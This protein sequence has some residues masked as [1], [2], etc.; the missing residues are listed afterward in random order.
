M[1]AWVL[2]AVLS[3]ACGI[4]WLLAGRGGEES[5]TDLAAERAEQ[6]Q[7]EDAD[8]HGAQRPGLLPGSPKPRP[9]RPPGPPDPAGT[10]AVAADAP[11]AGPVRVAGVVTNA[12]GVPVA[13]AHVSAVGL[14]LHATTDANGQFE[15]ELPPPGVFELIATTADTKGRA[16]VVS[17]TRGGRIE[18]LVVDAVT[19]APLL[20]IWVEARPSTSPSGGRASATALTDPTGAF[21]LVVPYEGEHDL[22]ASTRG[23]IR[24]G[25]GEGHRD[26][27][28]ARARTGDR[29]E[30]VE[31]RMEPALWI[32][33]RVLDERGDPVREEVWVNATGRAPD[34]TLDYTR[35]HHGRVVQGV[36]RLGGLAPGRY[37][38]I[39]RPAQV[40]EGSL[41][42]FAPV[43]L[44]SVE[45]GTRDLEVR[46]SHGHWLEGR[47]LGPDGQTLAGH[48]GWVQAS[49]PGEAEWRSEVR[50]A[51]LK[52]GTFRLGPLAALDRVD[53]HV[54][55][56]RGH[57]PHTEREVDP[58]VRGLEI[59][60]TQGGTIAG[61]VLTKDG[62]PAPAG[63]PIGLLAVGIDVSTPGA[64]P[65]VMTKS[66]GAFEATG[67]LEA[68]YELEAGGGTSGYIGTMATDVALGTTDLV[69]RVEE[70][71]D[72]VG[73]LVDKEGRP[74]SAQSLQ[75]DDGKHILA[76]RPYAQVG[77]DGLF[78]LRGLARGPVRL[79]FT[80]AGTWVALGEFTAPATDVKIVVP[81]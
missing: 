59:R 4:A 55:D 19:S 7:A 44:P 42:T 24:P 51:V 80:R 54:R 36:F 30:R 46:V 66:G 81:D 25:Q 77:Q 70:G 68:R 31:I 76:M 33:G 23:V 41:G 50:S 8:L 43:K 61:R 34:G 6:A 32:E 63:V 12:A 72:L 29:R 37:E 28:V 3:A 62:R 56:V 20:G 10:A 22:L 57:R 53:L 17:L 38:V 15:L 69:L 45:A 27:R 73:R 60:L 11:A 9:A 78:R 16:L 64:R 5:A 65:F 79:G 48:G 75:A 71:V 40:S 47:L 74:A 49:R 2:L 18:G 26:A 67:L 14:A 52:D 58:R 21:S 1:R 39:V 35:L 13:D